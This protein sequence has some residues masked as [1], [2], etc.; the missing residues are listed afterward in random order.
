MQGMAQPWK[1][2]FVVTAITLRLAYGPE[3]SDGR[4]EVARKCKNAMTEGKHRE[5]S[6]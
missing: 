5:N 4:N 6:E 2:D 1:T 3:V